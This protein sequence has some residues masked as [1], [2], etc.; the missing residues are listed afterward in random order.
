MGAATAQ[1]PGV[2]YIL[3]DS[4]GLKA[5]GTNGFAAPV[6]WPQWT[7]GADPFTAAKLR[8]A[9]RHGGA[10]PRS[11]VVEVPISTVYTLPAPADANVYYVTELVGH[12]A[13]I[14]PSGV[15]WFYY[16][17]TR[18]MDALTIEES[19]GIYTVT[20]GPVLSAYLTT[21]AADRKNLVARPE[22]PTLSADD[23]YTLEPRNEY[24]LFDGPAG[25]AAIGSMERMMLI[26]AAPSGANVRTCGSQVQY[27]TRVGGGPP[28]SGSAFYATGYWFGASLWD[29]ATWTLDAVLHDPGTYSVASAGMVHGW[30]YANEVDPET[31]K[32]VTAHQ[33]PEGCLTVVGLRG[34]FDSGGTYAACLSWPTGV[35]K[36]SGTYLNLGA[37]TPGPT[38]MWRDAGPWRWAVPTTFGA[39][40]GNVD[41]S[42]LPS[43]FDTSPFNFVP[44][45]VTPTLWR[46]YHSFE[47]PN[48]E[49]EA[50]GW[51]ELCSFASWDSGTG[52]LG[53]PTWGGTLP[54]AG[55]EIIITAFHADMASTADLVTLHLYPEATVSPVAI[56]LAHGGVIQGGTI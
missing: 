8:R 55:Q 39:E 40:W 7:A 5:G 38:V 51:H 18:G 37:S 46:G 49:L 31:G 52:E 50:G 25:A 15:D 30:C 14:P 11:W 26:K 44:D 47:Q 17:L 32:M 2:A 28:A 6:L 20:P 56:P 23:Y 48:A 27:F 35:R 43:P 21:V 54:T 13:L 33:M 10:I 45:T 3:A 16:D 42:A 36:L 34:L 4:A 22:A 29:G 19:G 24:H 41:N 53:D 1:W 12:A 9:Y